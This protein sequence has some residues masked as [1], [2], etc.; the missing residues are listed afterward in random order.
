[1]SGP[2]ILTL[3]REFAAPADR[4]FDAWLDPADASR[5]L[6]ATP[7]GEMKRVEIDARVGGEA[8][9]VER[10]AEGEARH[11][12]RF[13]VIDRP[14][15]LVFLFSADLSDDGKWT[16]VSIDIAATPAGCTLTLTHEMEA[17]WAGHA[18]QVR[19][20]WTMILDGLTRLLE[21][22]MID[23]ERIAPD[24]IRMERLLDA[25]VE[26]VW[27]WLTEPDLRRQWFAGGRIDPRV[28]GEI[29]LVFDHDDLSADD[30]PYPAQY[31]EYKGAIGRERIVEYDPP[32][33]F[34]ISWDEG[35]EG[36]ALFEL[37]EAGERTRLVLTHSGISGPGPMANFG[38][39][40][41]AHLAVLEARLA[42]RQVRDFWA[43][44]A[45][46]EEAVARQLR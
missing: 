22:T 29:E 20:G 42:G 18:P 28:G 2:V 13:E 26:T 7:A 4:V 38:G 6:F 35:R 25:P 44:H 40:W 5:F 34:A 39:G 43:L 10:R 37:F 36:T 12:L 19:S 3:A 9:I 30:V 15:R 45:Q 8:L 14:R 33:R 16:R 41:H 24:T 46:S 17:A 32:R 1:M 27:R 21:K 31:A 23:I 11:R